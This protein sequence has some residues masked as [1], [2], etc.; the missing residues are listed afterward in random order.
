MDV[1]LKKYSKRVIVGAVILAGVA[2]AAAGGLWWSYYKNASHDPEVLATVGAEKITKTDLNELIYAADYKG[3]ISNPVDVSQEKKNE[4]FSQL[5]RWSATKQEASKLGI[6]VSDSEYQKELKL[7]LGEKNYANFAK[8]YTKSQQELTK[9]VVTNEALSAKVEK[10][11]VT[12]RAGQVI[13]ARFDKYAGAAPTEFTD[14]QKAEWERVKTQSYQAD[15]LYAQTKINSIYKDLTVG[16]ITG[17]QAVKETLADV[18]LNNTYFSPWT[19]ALSLSFTADQFAKPVGLLTDEAV[20]TALLATGSGYTKPENVNVAL[21]D[22]TEVPGY[23]FFVNVEKS[24]SSDV[25]DMS[26]WLTKKLAGD[27]KIKLYAN[28]YS[29]VV[30]I[31]KTAWLATKVYADSVADCQNSNGNKWGVNSGS[32]SSTAGLIVHTRTYDLSGNLSD[33]SGIGFQVSGKPGANYIYIGTS[34]STRVASANFTTGDTFYK[35]S[36]GGNCNIGGYSVLG[37]GTSPSGKSYANWGNRYSLGCSG[38]PFAVTLTN[39]PGGDGYWETTTQSLNATNGYTSSMDFTWHVTNPNKRLTVLVDPVGSA[40]TTPSTA[41]YVRDTVVGPTF[42]INDTESYSFGSWEGCTTT[43]G[44][45]CSVKMDTDKTITLHLKV[46]TPE[47]IKCSVSPQVGLSPLV[48]KVTTDFKGLGKNPVFTYNFGS[49]EATQ[50]GKP[51]IVYYTYS[52][53]GNYVVTVKHE[54]T[55]LTTTCAPNP[56]QV[57]NPTD[58]NGGEVR[59]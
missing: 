56:I 17:D 53:A 29:G 13:V 20:R 2:L 8:L 47:I 21:D 24:N 59:P 12:S 23:Y 30:N 52:R 5:V 34:G 36:S 18:K 26:A 49:G 57:T 51:A 42:T 16:K 11:V 45:S 32:A 38:N 3:S 22:G 28:E 44:E 48:V 46:I 7:R 9:K 37:Y 19:A 10:E 33:L 4:Y 27:Y 39:T 54:T 55:G 6:T 14:T 50:V 40:V 35:T 31:E 41:I 58:S 25:A 43:N 1:F 15:K